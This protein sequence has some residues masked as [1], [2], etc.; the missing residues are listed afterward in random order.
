MMPARNVASPSGRLA[1]RGPG[2]AIL[3]DTDEPEPQLLELR[4]DLNPL[5]GNDAAS[6]TSASIK[7]SMS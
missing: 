4:R 3:I 6:A 1:L 2:T 5:H 7:P